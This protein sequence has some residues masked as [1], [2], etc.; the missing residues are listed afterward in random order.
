MTGGGAG[1]EGG[2]PVVLIGNL[3]DKFEEGS[4]GTILATLLRSLSM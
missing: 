4:E 3:S 2:G 1:K